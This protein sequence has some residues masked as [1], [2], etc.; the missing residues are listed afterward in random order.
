MKRTRKRGVVFILALVMTLSVITPAAAQEPEND[1]DAHWAATYI[2]QAVR[3]G[4]A[5]MHG[6]LFEPDRAVTRAEFAHMMT[7][8]LGL[9][10]AGDSTFT[11]VE[12][13]NPYYK[14]I[15]TAVAAGILKGKET[16]K[17]YP[18][19]EITRQEA[20]AIISRVVP[21]A[22]MLDQSCLETF[23]DVDKIGSWAREALAICKNK[24]YIIGNELGY[25]NPQGRLTRAEAVKILCVI[26]DSEDIV[27]EDVTLSGKDPALQNK[28]VVGNV[29][30]S[31]AAKGNVLLRNNIIFGSVTAS[32]GTG[33]R[34]QDSC[35]SYQLIIR[36]TPISFEVTAVGRTEIA[37]V[38]RYELRSVVNHA[39]AVGFS[40]VGRVENIFA[41]ASGGGGGGGGASRPDIQNRPNAQRVTQMI[42]A[43]PEPEAVEKTTVN[44]YKD[45]IWEAKKRLDQLTKTELGSVDGEHQKKLQSLIDKVGQYL[46]LIPQVKSPEIVLSAGEAE[47]VWRC[48]TVPLLQPETTKLVYE[49]KAD[50]VG[51]EE[52]SDI[53]R[54]IGAEKEVDSAYEIYVQREIHAAKIQTEI[55]SANGLPLQLSIREDLANKA[56][57]EVVYMAADGSCRPQNAIVVRRG[58]QYFLEFQAA[59][60]TEEPVAGRNVSGQYVVTYD[61]Q[62]AAPSGRFETPQQLKVQKDSEKHVIVSFRPVEGAQKYLIYITNTQTAEI[63][64]FETIQTTLDITDRLGEGGRTYQVQVAAKALGDMATSALSEAVSIQTVWGKLAAPQ[65]LDSMKQDGSVTVSFEADPAGQLVQ[66]S[67]LQADTGAFIGSMTTGK[68][69]ADISALLLLAP[70][71]V[72]RFTVRAVSLGTGYFDTSDAADLLLDLDQF[73]LRYSAGENGAVLGETDQLVA[74]GEDGGEVTAR[75]NTGYHFLRWSDG[76]ETPVRQEKNVENDINVSAQFEINTYHLSY[77]AAGQGTV[78][79]PTDQYVQHGGDGTG[80][81]AVA[82]EGYEFAGWSDG[83]LSASRTDLDVTGDII[84]TAQFQR[85]Q[86]TLSYVAGPNGSVLGDVAQNVYHGEDGTEVEAVPN[87]TYLWLRWS[88]GMIEPKRQEKDV[89]QDMTL[90]ALF[91]SEVVTV[92]YLATEYGSVSGITTQRL[93]PGETTMTV[94]AV[95]DEGGRFVRWSDGVTT[96]ERSDVDVRSNMTITAEFEVGSHTVTYIAGEHGS[97]SGETVQRVEY[98]EN[99]KQVVAV[100]DAHYHFV[101]WS[102]GFELPQRIDYEVKENRTWTAQFAPNT[103]AVIITGGTGSATYAYGDTVTIEFTPVDGQRFKN[104]KVTSGSVTLADATAEKTTFIMPDSI[105][106]IQAEFEFRLGTCGHDGDTVGAFFEGT[107]TA[108]DPFK[109]T[110]PQQFIHIK[111]HIGEGKCYVQENDLDFDGVAFSPIGV[112]TPFKGVYDGSGNVIKNVKYQDS[113]NTMAALFLLM[114]ETGEIKNVVTDASCAFEARLY[115]AGIIANAGNG[116]VQNCVNKA[117]VTATQAAGGITATTAEKSTKEVVR[118][119]RNEGTVTATGE[120]LGNSGGIVGVNGAVVVACYNSGTVTAAKSGGGIAGENKGSVQQNYNAGTVYSTIN[121]G[122]VVGF[123]TGAGV[124]DTCYN[125]GLIYGDTDSGGLAGYNAAM[126]RNIYNVA[127]IGG[128]KKT[129]GYIGGVIGYNNKG[130][131]VSSYNIGKVTGTTKAN[132][133]GIIGYNRQSGTS[134][135]NNYYLEGTAAGAIGGKNQTG[136]AEMRSLDQ[137]I[138]PSFAVL[139][140]NSGAVWVLDGTLSNPTG[141]QFPQLSLLPH[142]GFFPTFDVRMAVNLPQP[143]DE[144]PAPPEEEVQPPTPEETLPPEEAEEPTPSPQVTPEESPTDA[145]EET[146]QP[147]ETPEA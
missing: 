36:G 139:L 96:P 134:I 72:R 90:T 66:I 136:K 137:M 145:P 1:V 13:D 4:F 114:D 76:E 3:G 40:G 55:L 48:D 108:E 106:R 2:Y 140:N 117:E 67:L 52:I 138:I 113:S 98:G 75:G 18:E 121:A 30:I 87:D 112:T 79:G 39:L 146:A 122:G 131:V 50:A 101:Q 5:D 111:Q 53:R 94:T 142:I 78:E 80:V 45:S 118:N 61:K 81:K 62:S 56:G 144:E 42:E 133:G 21:S 64:Y 83:V 44:T 43:L 51:Q 23:H 102:D 93:Q 116:L 69:Q 130:S 126:M 41:S 34:V 92:Q 20:G 65:Q 129:T 63:S 132:N 82:E 125:A 7:A 6:G 100:P 109:V 135:Q 35:L 86:Y 89:R 85:K 57:L 17:F 84:V 49:L 31:S 28:I 71:E 33:L 95:P 10:R 46:V 15:Q 141:F 54:I 110:T 105:V 38:R 14:D 128:W 37:L 22:D 8:M 59:E 26:Q 27:R 120:K 127:Q 25:M 29:N 115:A 24:G 68:E 32:G 119:C 104:W 103:N 11:D 77:T 58:G 12:K 60:E 73:R 99:S 91:A 124:V 123:N 107:G 70:P 74:R 97:I 19:G 88:D 16:S 147:E 47:F 9:S 143:T